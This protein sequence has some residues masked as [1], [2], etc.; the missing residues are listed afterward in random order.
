MTT[1]DCNNI[2]P[3]KNETSTNIVDA[4]IAKSKYLTAQEYMGE[5]YIGI[6]GDVAINKLLKEKRG[7]VKNA[8]ERREIGEI[9]L[10]WGDDSGGLQHIIKQRTKQNI[11]GIQLIR[12]I[13]QIVDNGTL[14][15][16]K[17]G[18]HIDYLNQRVAIST[19]LRG[20]DILWI[21]TAYELDKQKKL[22]DY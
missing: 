11:D 22:L 13:P 9:Y 15:Q 17:Y 19:K 6:S 14:E 20:L 2:K 3:S 7:F 1:N 10:V 4:T 12:R 16:D 18:L 5:E 21:V 8:F